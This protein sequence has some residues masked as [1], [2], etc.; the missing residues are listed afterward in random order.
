MSEACK[1]IPGDRVAVWITQRDDVKHYD[2]G[3]V[4]ATRGSF[5]SFYV[6]VILDT[7][8]KLGNYH[9]ENFYK[10]RAK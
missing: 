8:I 9:E 6:D 5:G 10:E 1:F 3:I 2:A 4:V 7:G